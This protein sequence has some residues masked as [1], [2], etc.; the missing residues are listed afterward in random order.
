MLHGVDERGCWAARALRGHSLR[1]P[2]SFSTGLINDF[3]AAD[4]LIWGFFAAYARNC[5]RVGV[6]SLWRKRSGWRWRTTMGRTSLTELPGGMRGIVRGERQPVPRPAAPLLAALSRDALDLLG[7]V[8]R[9]RPTSVTMLVTLTGRSQPNVSRPLQMLAKHR[10]ICL[11]REGRE[12]R[13]EPIAGAVWM[14]LAT[15][16]YETTPLSAPAGRPRTR[17]QRRPGQTRRRYRAK[18]Y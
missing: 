9:E 3:G 2:A 11:V 14:D 7:V 18:N 16:T 17:P 6:A 10:L 8:L 5:R 15:G 13:P 12:V 4:E 1:S